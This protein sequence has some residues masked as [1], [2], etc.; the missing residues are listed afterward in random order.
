MILRGMRGSVVNVIAIGWNSVALS[1]FLMT[2]DCEDITALHEEG[3][4]DAQNNWENI[5]F[6]NMHTLYVHRLCKDNVEGVP[7]YPLARAILYRAKHGAPI[8]HVHFND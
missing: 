6:I 3:S 1:A 2:G 5:P 7:E 8:K 4:Q